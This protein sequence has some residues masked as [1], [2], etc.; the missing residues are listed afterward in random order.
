MKGL[1]FRLS[2]LA[3][4]ELRRAYAGDARSEFSCGLQR[5]G[6]QVFGGHGAVY[7]KLLS[8]A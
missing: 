2:K 7:F 1:S 8:L 5:D 3:N 4:S 6:W